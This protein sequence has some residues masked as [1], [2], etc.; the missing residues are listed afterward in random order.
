[1]APSD[2]IVVAALV[3]RGLHALTEVLVVLRELRGVRR[4]LLLALGGRGVRLGRVLSLRAP[5]ARPIAASSLA[6]NPSG[7]LGS[8]QEDLPRC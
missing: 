6:A 4:L 3:L 8:G 5:R 7:S 2:L 1:M